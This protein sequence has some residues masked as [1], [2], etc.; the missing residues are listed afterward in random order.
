MSVCLHLC[1]YINRMKGNRRYI[2]RNVFLYKILQDN[3][4]HEIYFPVQLRRFKEGKCSLVKI[5][6]PQILMKLKSYW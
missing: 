4:L 1:L 2:K 5:Q 6:I 3:E